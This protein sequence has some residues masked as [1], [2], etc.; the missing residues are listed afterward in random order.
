M[1]IGPYKFD[2]LEFAGSLGDLGT[3]IPLSVALML[4]TG[5]SVTTV[6]LTVGLFY[7]AAGAYFKLPIPVQPLKVVSAIA[8]AYPG[9]I[10][11]SIMAA[12]G[13]SFGFILLLMAFT[14]LIDRLAKFFTRPI[15]RGIQTGLG[16]ILIQ[17]GIAFILNAELFINPETT[18]G[19]SRMVNPAIGI[20]GFLVAL[21]LLTNKKFPAALVLVVMGIASGVLLG[22]MRDTTF[23][24]GPTPVELQSLTPADFYTALVLLVIPQIPLT[25]G[26]AV[27][28]TTDTCFTLF[29]R[30]QVPRQVSNRAF[31]ISMGLANLGAGLLGGMPMCHGAGGLA[32]HHRFGARTGGSNIM[33][34]VIFLVVALGFGRMGIALLSSI[35]NGILGVLL[36]FAGMELALLIRDVSGKTDFFITFLVAG[37][38]LATTNMGIAFFIGILVQGLLKWRRIDI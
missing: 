6:L 33:I 35:P 38:G 23:A 37:I 27:I 13:V 34:G 20:A 28:G 5:L 16:L 30:E 26:N 36:L 11:L 24:L 22:S 12:A 15:I 29:G 1:R 14:G 2:R 8:I 9:K 7:I 4:I 25:L 21:C 31:S 32:A 19:F 3:I 10:T 17:K 18:A